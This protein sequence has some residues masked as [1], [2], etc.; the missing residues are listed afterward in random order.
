MPQAKAG[1]KC[2]ATGAGRRTRCKSRLQAATVSRPCRHGRPSPLTPERRMFSG[3]R[4]GASRNSHA[5]GQRAKPARGGTAQTIPAIQA[6]P[7]GKRIPLLHLHGLRATAEPGLRQANTCPRRRKGACKNNSTLV[8][9]PLQITARN[10]R[11][12][13]PASPASRRA[14]N[15]R[16][17]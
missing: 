11:P 16:N 6:V 10:A 5:S 13:S 7:Q 15:A 4:Q 1:R 2:R 17:S 14:S 3:M 12:F 8:L 9:Q